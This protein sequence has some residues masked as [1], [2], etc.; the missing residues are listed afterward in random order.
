MSLIFAILC[1]NPCWELIIKHGHYINFGT[2]DSSK[3]VIFG[4][5]I[6]GSSSS[7]SSII[8]VV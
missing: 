6:R 5:D 2:P 7:S 3:Y 8:S 1:I 4:T